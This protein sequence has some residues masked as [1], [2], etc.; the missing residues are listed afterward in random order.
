MPY[1]RKS[2]GIRPLPKGMGQFLCLDNIDVITGASCTGGISTSFQTG[3]C[4]GGLDAVTGVP[5]GPGTTPINAVGT[6]SGSNSPNPPSTGC[7]ALFGDGASCWGPI[8]SVTWLAL[9]GGLALGL[10]FLSKAP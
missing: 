7:L 5:C 3:L 9:G 2:T 10:W 4:V 8:G 6:A 1:I